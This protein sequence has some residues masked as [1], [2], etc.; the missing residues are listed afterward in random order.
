MLPP[1]PIP[2][3]DWLIA[4][5]DECRKQQVA[6]GERP[7]RALQKWVKKNGQHQ[8]LAQLIL[9]HLATEAFNTI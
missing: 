4:F 6:V 9:A 7:F 2:P 8:P 1:L 5:N 3:Q